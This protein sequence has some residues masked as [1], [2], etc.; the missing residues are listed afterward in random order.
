MTE[1]RDISPKPDPEPGG[2]PDFDTWG[3]RAVDS[4]KNPIKTPGYPTSGA[5]ETRQNRAKIGQLDGPLSKL[6]AAKSGSGLVSVEDVL[7]T[8]NLKDRMEMARLRHAQILAR[9]SPQKPGLK[10]EGVQNSV[11]R[12]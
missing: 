4:Q 3:R 6:D 11:S 2:F 1:R 7:N 12:G 8:A 5:S 9:R 10:T